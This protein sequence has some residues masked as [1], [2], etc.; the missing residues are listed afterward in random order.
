[1]QRAQMYTW[2]RVVQIRE[3]RSECAE[4]LFERKRERLDE[5]AWNFLLQRQR[6]IVSE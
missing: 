6:V 2:Q 3:Y 1:M 4:D 5:M